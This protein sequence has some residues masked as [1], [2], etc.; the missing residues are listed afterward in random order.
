MELSTYISILAIVL[1]SAAIILAYRADAFS[2]RPPPCSHKWVT[3]HEHPILNRDR[4]VGTSIRQ[5]CEHCGD[6]KFH[7]VSVYD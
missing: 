3:I 1:S 4:H 2:K 6:L 7:N 5:Q